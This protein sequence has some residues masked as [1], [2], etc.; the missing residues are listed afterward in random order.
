MM[1]FLETDDDMPPTLGE[2]ITRSS[3]PEHGVAHTALADAQDVVYMI[4]D[5]LR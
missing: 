1:L 4:F 5:G 3:L 2:C